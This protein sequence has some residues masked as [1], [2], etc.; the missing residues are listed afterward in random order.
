[1]IRFLTETVSLIVLWLVTGHIEALWLALEWANEPC[2]SFIIC[3][4]SPQR[5]WLT[6]ARQRSVTAVF[7][8]RSCH[9][10]RVTCHGILA[11]GECTYSDRCLDLKISSNLSF[12]INTLRNLNSQD[13]HKQ[14]ET[15]LE[16]SQVT[17]DSWPGDRRMALTDRKLTWVCCGQHPPRSPCSPC[18]SSWVGC[19]AVWWTDLGVKS[20]S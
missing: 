20:E 6:G 14:K 13:F 1:M 3:V 12:P 4:W 15:C 17:A 5:V 18:S 19:R 8:S 9:V 11:W 16:G 2:G 10:S 7:L